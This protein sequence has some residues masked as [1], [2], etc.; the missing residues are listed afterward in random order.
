L[1]WFVVQ[2]GVR[3]TTRLALLAGVLA[4]TLAAFVATKTA[5]FAM[6]TG[7]SFVIPPTIL[8][9]IGYAMPTNLPTCIAAIFLSDAIFEAY[10]FFMA[11]LR[12][13]HLALSNT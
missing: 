2:L 10:G 13:V 9:P 12:T 6:V 11:Q 7:L 4:V 3:I 5:V 8:L 1:G